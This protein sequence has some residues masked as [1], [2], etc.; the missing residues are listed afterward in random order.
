MGF[1]KSDSG[2]PVPAVS[3]RQFESDRHLVHAFEW[4]EPAVHQSQ[5]L[6]VCPL[7]R[8]PFATGYAAGNVPFWKRMLRQALLVDGG[9][10]MGVRRGG[11]YMGAVAIHFNC[12]GRG[13]GHVAKRSKI[14]EMG[15]W[16]MNNESSQQ[17]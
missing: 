2:G 16:V 1:R 6:R 9:G 4:P 8:L 13:G 17:H 7:P 10:G 15:F 11:A 12:L 14:K 5:P 3:C